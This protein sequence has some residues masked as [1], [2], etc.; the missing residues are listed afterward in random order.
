M[1]GDSA[2]LA[3]KDAKYLNVSACSSLGSSVT[4]KV[5]APELGCCGN[6]GTK[7]SGRL[8]AAFSHASMVSTQAT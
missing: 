6:T 7:S 8:W 3:M 4:W 2:L 5:S 1:T